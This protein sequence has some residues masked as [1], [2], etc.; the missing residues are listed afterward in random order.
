M[1]LFRAVG[2]VATP[3]TVLERD[4]CTGAPGDPEVIT[5]IF[6][7]V[8]NPCFYT[9]ICEDDRTLEQ[10]RTDTALQFR[11]LAEMLFDP[12]FLRAPTLRHPT[13]QT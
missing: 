4:L 2:V 10:H 6:N 13:E 12:A 5:R 1:G 3:S 11:P 7:D 8:W 9:L